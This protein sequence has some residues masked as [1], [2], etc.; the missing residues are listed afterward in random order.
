MDFDTITNSCATAL[1]A[2]NDST[3]FARGIGIEMLLLAGADVRAVRHRLHDQ[4]H[5]VKERGH[6]G[7]VGDPLD[8][9]GEQGRDR[10]Q[11]DAL[12]TLHHLVLAD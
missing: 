5:L 4:L 3:N 1:S 12:G 10:Q 2:E 6:R 9:L 11:T 8:R 7:F